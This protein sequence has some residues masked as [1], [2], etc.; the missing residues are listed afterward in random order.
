MSDQSA[1]IHWI[2][3]LCD[4]L[5]NQLSKQTHAVLSNE[6]KQLRANPPSVCDDCKPIDYVPTS[7][8]ACQ[9]KLRRVLRRLAWSRQVNVLQ[10]MALSGSRQQAKEIESLHQEIQSLNK[11]LKRSQQQLRSLLGV[12]T[13]QSTTV[14]I[15]DNE[16][17]S[18]TPRKK[19]GAPKG[20][21]GKSRPLPDHVDRIKTVPPPGQ[22]DH[23]GASQITLSDR[24][25]HSDFYAAYNQF[26]YTQK[27]L[28]HYLRDIKN[29]LKVSPDDKALWQLR[30]YLKKLITLG[31]KVQRLKRKRAIDKG[32]HALDQL[33]KKIT[34]LTSD[35][36][37][38]QTLINRAIK[39][40]N[41]LANFVD[42]PQAEFHNNWAEQTIRFAVI[43]R[44]LS[45]GHRT[46]QGAGLFCVLT[47]VLDTCRL[48]RINTFE[49]LNAVFLCNPENQHELVK[50]IFAP[51]LALPKQ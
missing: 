8:P 22:C 11:Q 49:F 47:S 19:R 41:C 38:T 50:N 35:N 3:A 4:R 21:V 26:P 14:A 18:K 24:V 42:H 2:Q 27:C 40:Q 32:K 25:I 7:L 29:E 39:Y 37:K 28:V 45:F 20:H 48:N 1:D 23:C 43:F 33:I 31:K 13:A 6:L 30:L 15:A 51:I 46:V 5:I 10:E 44:K 12:D 17:N 36:E 9:Q 34:R 16:D